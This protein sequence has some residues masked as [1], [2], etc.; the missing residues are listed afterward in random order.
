MYHVFL[1]PPPLHPVSLIFLSVHP[2]LWPLPLPFCWPPIQQ[3]SHDSRSAGV[4]VLPS[5]TLNCDF[6][7]L[8][9]HVYC[10][11][12]V[13]RRYFPFY[14]LRLLSIKREQEMADCYYNSLTRVY[15]FCKWR[16]P[17]SLDEKVLSS[18][19]SF[20]SLRTMRL[21]RYHIY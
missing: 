5:N 6:F 8:N 9:F 3:L 21:M 20:V 15:L 17:F 2:F 18:W 1:L 14:Y 16:S 10:C 7:C 4:N 19:V 11:Y 12:E 13:H